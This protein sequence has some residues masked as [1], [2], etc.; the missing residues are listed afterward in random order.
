[1]PTPRK[2]H[3]ECTKKY[4]DIPTCRVCKW[5]FAGERDATDPTL[6]ADCANRLRKQ[7]D[8]YA[9]IEITRSP[10]RFMS[11]F[12]DGELKYP[13]RKCKTKTCRELVYI[14]QSKSGYCRG[15]ATRERFKRKEKKYA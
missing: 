11:E 4:H 3:Y 12:H 8:W 14:H 10:A 15:C 7:I 13:Q 6:C 1:M 9:P 2:R 5:P